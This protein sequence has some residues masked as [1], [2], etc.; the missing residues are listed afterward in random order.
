MISWG[1]A[2]LDAIEAYGCSPC[3]C[4][5][6]CPWPECRRQKQE[7]RE[8]LLRLLRRAADKDET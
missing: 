8:T 2:M 7:A 5:T 3:A 4:N 6:P 1:Q